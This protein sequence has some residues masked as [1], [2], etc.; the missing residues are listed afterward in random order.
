MKKKFMNEAIR[1]AKKAF[2]KDEV[3]VGAVIVKDNKII[4][5]A[6]NSKE[7]FDCVINHAEIIAI[8]KASKKLKNWRLKDCDVY[9]TFEPCPMCASAIK[10]ARISNVYA[11]LSNSDHDNELIIKKIFESDHNNSDV[12]FY[13]N[14]FPGES[15]KL[16]KNFF[17]LKRKK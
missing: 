8:I 13:N 4:A 16:M 15:Q 14:V 10:Q 6:Y 12:N 11:A 1:Q 3:P 5:R 17:E 2:D 7:K 9:V